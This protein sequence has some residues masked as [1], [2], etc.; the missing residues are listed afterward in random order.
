MSTARYTSWLAI[1]GVVA[2]VVLTPFVESGSIAGVPAGVVLIA[3]AWLMIW[4]LGVAWIRVSKRRRPG[5]AAVIAIGVVVL[6]VFVGAPW[7]LGA[8]ANIAV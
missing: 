1:L 4:L 6:G 5:L 8:V 2:L 3:L 7:I